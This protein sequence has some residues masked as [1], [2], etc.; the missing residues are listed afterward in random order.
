MKH[1][2]ITRGRKKSPRSG[3]FVAAR[4]RL[5]LPQMAFGSV[6]ARPA[7][8]AKTELPSL[9][10]VHMTRHLTNGD[11]QKRIPPSEDAARPVRRF[12]VEDCAK[13][14]RGLSNP[15]GGKSPVRRATG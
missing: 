14:I 4:R 10:Q 12:E 13:Q 2:E 1:G 15:L 8:R 11:T 6:L 7:S 5:A 3:T 9:P